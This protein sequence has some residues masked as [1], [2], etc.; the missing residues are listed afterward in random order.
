M[1]SVR[2]K[3]TNFVLNIILNQ[4]RLTMKADVKNTMQIHS[5]AKVDFYKTY[6]EKYVSILCQSQYIRHI[7]IYDVFCGMG[8]YDD[9]G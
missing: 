9:G 3:I 2:I 6:L 1:R 5:R 7:R 4:I 8:I